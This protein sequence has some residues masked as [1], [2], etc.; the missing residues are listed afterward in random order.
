MIALNLR[1]QSED[2]TDM[3]LASPNLPLARGG[4]AHG[5]VGGSATGV[6]RPNSPVQI[7]TVIDEHNFLSDESAATIRR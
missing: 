3:Q 4:S 5:G 1:Q 6:T 7:V 2:K